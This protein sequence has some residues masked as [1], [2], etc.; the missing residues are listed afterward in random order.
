MMPETNSPIFDNEPRQAVC[1]IG[2]GTV[3]RAI[4]REFLRH[5]FDVILCDIAAPSLDAAS[6][7]MTHEFNDVSATRYASVVSGMPAIRLSRHGRN[8]TPDDRESISLVIESIPENLSLKQALFAELST[9]MPRDTVLASNTSNLRIGDVFASMTNDERC[10]GLHFFMPVGERPLVEF[11]RAGGTSAST[12]ARCERLARQIGKAT[13]VVKDSPGF[14]VNRL[15]VPY[16]NQAFLLLERDISATQLADAA[17]RF[18]MPLSPL[19][20]VD[21]IGIRTAFDSGRIF[22]QSFPERLDPAPTLPGMIKAGRLGRSFGGGFFS[23]SS[24]S[25]P[26][27]PLKDADNLHPA[28]EAVIA[29]YQR[30]HQSWSDAELTQVLAIP[31]W[32]EAAEV[33]ATGVVDDFDSVELAMRCGL[34]YRNT[35]G[36]FGFFDRMG[37]DTLRHHLIDTGKLFRGLRATDTLVAALDASST[38]SEALQ[39]YMHRNRED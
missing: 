2:A 34:G 19:A 15:L 7:E 24:G 25:K 32:I 26:L 35:S 8:Y 39:R 36:F 10:C 6:C 14:V 23:A 9:V 30:G 13:L 33:L 31:M 12:Q 29:K 18:G 37:I 11:I 27:K 20:L 38:A 22:W 3:G 17:D 28:A 21:A 1:L 4:L 16:L 5:D